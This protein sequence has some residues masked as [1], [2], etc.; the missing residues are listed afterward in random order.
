MRKA[1]FS[2]QYASSEPHGSASVTCIAVPL[3]RSLTGE[4]CAAC[5]LNA[6]SAAWRRQKLLRTA[7]DAIG[8]RKPGRAG[9][10]ADGGKTPTP[11]CQTPF[12][13]RP[14]SSLSA[15][16]SKTKDRNRSSS[17]RNLKPNSY[18]TH[19]SATAVPARRAGRRRLF[20]GGNRVSG[21]R[22]A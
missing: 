1:S 9:Y 18:N 4:Q 8:R 5:P 7:Q 12:M 15:R 3:R 2:R 22:C 14:V 10:R 17:Y 11:S 19:L 21:L 20:S 13:Q 6:A 16:R